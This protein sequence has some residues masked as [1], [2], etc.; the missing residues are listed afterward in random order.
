MAMA[1]ER[2]AVADGRPGRAGVAVWRIDC[3]PVVPGRIVMRAEDGEARFVSLD[4]GRSWRPVAVAGDV[5]R[6]A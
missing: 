3:D 4:N 1:V 5:V 6:A 2:H